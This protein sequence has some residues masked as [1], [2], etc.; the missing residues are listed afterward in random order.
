MDDARVA[1]WFFEKK[2]ELII[3]KME[4]KGFA[5][6]YAATAEGAGKAVLAMIP[7]G[8]AVILTGSQTLEQIGVKPHLRDSGK[9]N[10]IDPYEPG[11]TPAEGLARR[12]KGLLADVMVS[13]SNALTED[14]VLVNVDGMGNRVA[15]MIFGPDKVILALGMNKVVK[16]LPEAYSRLSRIAGP[17]NNKRLESKNP[18]AETGF[19]HDCQG[20]TRICNYFTRI[21]R[22]FI[23]GRIAVILI[24][25]DLGY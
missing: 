14:G 4:K 13:S 3:K 9:Y 12:K 5:A 24:G 10:L 20:K 7:E 2:A 15:G 25:Q 21:E 18:C 8:A 16:D 23:E 1:S 19:C 17:M 22:S 11:I 6:H